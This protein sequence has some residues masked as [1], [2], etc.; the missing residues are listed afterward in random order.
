MDSAMREVE[1][2]MDRIAH[3][4][5]LKENENVVCD[6]YIWSGLAYCKVFNPSVFDFIKVLYHHNYFRK[7]D[8]YVFV[9]TPPEIC[10]QR[11]RIPAQFSNLVKLRNAFI[12]TK[13]LISNYSTVFTLDTEEGTKNLDELTEM[14]FKRIEILNG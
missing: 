10:C 1:F 13:P 9:D 11:R 5:F 2:L 4:E 6:R 3:Q 8:L 14:V 7:P 12:E